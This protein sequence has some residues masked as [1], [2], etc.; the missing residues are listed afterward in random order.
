MVHPISCHD[1]L[2]LSKLSKGLGN[3]PPSVLKK[4]SQG[5]FLKSYKFNKTTRLS[6]YTDLESVM[7]GST[8]AQLMTVSLWKG[9]KKTTILCERTFLLELKG[10]SCSD[11][12]CHC[13]CKRH[14][15]CGSLRHS[16]DREAGRQRQ[17]TGWGSPER[18][19][20]PVPAQHP[21][22][23]VKGHFGGS[24]RMESHGGARRDWKSA[25]GRQ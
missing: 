9:T 8:S 24:I 21:C 17:R 6:F 11:Y 23:E 18:R 1:L 15:V 3:I 20:C 12:T 16:L 2:L 4:K 14:R 7:M 5:G 13:C 22:E 19:V 25:A 10:C